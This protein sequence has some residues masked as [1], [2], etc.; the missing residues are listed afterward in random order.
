MQKVLPI[1]SLNL[2]TQKGWDIS[3]YAAS[4]NA[5]LMFKAVHRDDHYIFSKY[6]QAI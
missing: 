6:Y 1:F 2:I 5:E 3:N 4:E